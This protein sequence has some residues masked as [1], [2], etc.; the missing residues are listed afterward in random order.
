[1]ATNTHTDEEHHN[2]QVCFADNNNARCWEMVDKCSV[3]SYAAAQ[4]TLPYFGPWRNV[5]IHLPPGHFP[6]TR[7]TSLH[8]QFRWSVKLAAFHQIKCI[9]N[10]LEKLEAAKAA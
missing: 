5:N 7:V 8:G 1:M 2:L 4:Q 3:S 10:Q 6:G 9:V